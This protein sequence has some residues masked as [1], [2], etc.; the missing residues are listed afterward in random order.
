M[1]SCVHTYTCTCKHTRGSS[2]MLSCVHIYTHV[3]TYI[4]EEA[5]E[6][7]RVYCHV[8]LMFD[9]GQ[10]LIFL[11]RV[12]MFL[13]VCLHAYADICQQ[14][15]AQIMHL[16][17]TRYVS[18]IKCIYKCTCKHAATY[19]CAQAMHIHNSRIYT[20]ATTHTTPHTHPCAH[21]HACIHKAIQ[22]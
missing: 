22:M 3:H 9:Q 4:H 18:C 8:C 19:I 12:C 2:R 1:L 21:M 10:R 15:C 13:Y 6:C 5:R 17:A 16:W 11:V 20:H 7:S 14:T